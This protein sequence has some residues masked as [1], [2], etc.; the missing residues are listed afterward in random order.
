MFKEI[1]YPIYSYMSTKRKRRN[2]VSSWKT[3]IRNYGL[4]KSMNYSQFFYSL[5]TGPT[6]CAFY[7]VEILIYLHFITLFVTPSYVHKI[8]P[9]RTFGERD[10]FLEWKLR[11]SVRDPSTKKILWKLRY[12]RD[13]ISWAHFFFFFSLDWSFFK[14]EMYTYITFL[15][16]IKINCSRD[17]LY[18]HTSNKI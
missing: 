18:L 5:I 6:D 15:K 8:A 14:K 17:I 13:F 10:S 11:Y 16:T 2:R 9:R 7:C 4:A 1:L 12:S 3:L